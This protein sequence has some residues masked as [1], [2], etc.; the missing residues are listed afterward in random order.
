MVRNG[1]A[2]S[3]I[4]NIN[5]TG[6]AGRHNFS[7]VRGGQ[8]YAY[9]INAQAG[10]VHSAP[11]TLELRAVGIHLQELLLPKRLRN[12]VMDEGV[13]C[14]YFNHCVVQEYRGQDFE[15]LTGISGSQIT[16][17]CGLHNDIGVDKRGR[18]C[19][20]TLAAYSQAVKK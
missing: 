9:T 2:S 20:M 15:E 16:T 13:E 19:G 7:E 11:M 1:I 5:E 4:V 12:S 6:R 18:L 3:K 14:A 8:H 10:D 17:A